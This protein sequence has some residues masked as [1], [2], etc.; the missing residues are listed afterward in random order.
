[1]CVAQASDHQ[2]A[3]TTFTVLIFEFFVDVLPIII[4]LILPDFLSIL[5]FVFLFRRVV[6]PGV[7]ILV[8]AVSQHD[9]LGS[10]VDATLGGVQSKTM[11]YRHA[12]L[13]SPLKE[14]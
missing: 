3:G 11:W 4:E 1:M 12:S 5:L 6:S 9:H 8:I 10:T 14:S 13:L 7:T 2:I